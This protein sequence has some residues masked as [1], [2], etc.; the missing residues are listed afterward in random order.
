M[1]FFGSSS[2][3]LKI[4][5][6]LLAVS[7]LISL[8]ILLFSK[9]IYLAVL[10]FSI[11]A[12]ISFLLNIGSEMFVAYHFLW[13]GYF[14]LLIWPLLNIFLIIHYARTKPKK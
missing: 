7:F 12:N 3:D 2:I 6:F 1:L 13:F 14:S 11:L 8:V 4:T 10:V 9:K 5:I